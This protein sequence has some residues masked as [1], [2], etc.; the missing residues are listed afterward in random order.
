MAEDDLPLLHDWL[1]R[2][3]PALRGEEPTDHHM[4]VVDGRTSG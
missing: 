1:R 3:R 2:P 4:I